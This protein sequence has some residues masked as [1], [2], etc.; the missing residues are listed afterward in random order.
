MTLRE[1]TIRGEHFVWDDQQLDNPR[2][3]LFDAEWWRA[4]EE[5]LAEAQGRGTAYFLAGQRDVPWVLR[6]NRRGGALARIN[7]DRFLYTGW[8][9]M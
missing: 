8:N 1:A 4:R 6:H 5:L 2:P 7:S 3:E 9:Q